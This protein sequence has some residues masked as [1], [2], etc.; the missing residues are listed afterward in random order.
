MCW[1]EPSCAGKNL[2]HDKIH[3]HTLRRF[4]QTDVQ[5]LCPCPTS[6]ATVDHFASR[7]AADHRISATAWLERLDALLAVEKG[8]VFLSH[9]LLDHIP[10]LL[11]EIAAYL[12]APADQEIAAN[13][14][15]M[16]KAGELGL[17]RFDQNAS[18]TSYCVNIRS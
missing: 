15:V 8:D 14:G 2:P 3:T 11:K 5:S 4:H 6:S 17:L 9:Q 18:V 13:T 1:Q 7:L 12:R 16:T 10:E